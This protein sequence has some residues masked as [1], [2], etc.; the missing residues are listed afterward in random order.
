MSQYIDR[1]LVIG[2]DGVWGVCQWWLVAYAVE[3][4]VAGGGTLWIVESRVVCNV[5]HGR[6]Y[7]IQAMVS[8][9][10]TWSL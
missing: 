2:L 5:N 4:P 10:G 6:G 9:N 3:E 1:L 8:G 7:F